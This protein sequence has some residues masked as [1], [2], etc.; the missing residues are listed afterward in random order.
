MLCPFF[1]SKLKKYLDGG[2]I[3]FILKMPISTSWLDRIQTDTAPYD[4]KDMME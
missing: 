4:L 3:S 1:L 2:F